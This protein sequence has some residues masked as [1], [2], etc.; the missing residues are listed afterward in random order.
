VSIDPLTLIE[1]LPAAISKVTED[2]S[3][4]NLSFLR[5]RASTAAL[6]QKTELLL[7]L[8]EDHESRPEQEPPDY[9]A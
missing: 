2:E 8:L 3:A 6:A 5:Y 4:A 1:S 9:F 7:K